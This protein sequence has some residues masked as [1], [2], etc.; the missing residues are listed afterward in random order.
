M[1]H[2]NN[3]SPTGNTYTT[4]KD[5]ADAFGVKPRTLNN[6]QALARSIEEVQTAVENN[7]IKSTTGFDIAR[8]DEQEQRQVMQKINSSPSKRLTGEDVKKII[9]EIKAIKPNTMLQ[10]DQSSN[11]QKQG[12]E[13]ISN[14]TAIT[15]TDDDNCVV[16]NDINNYIAYGQGDKYEQREFKHFIECV[17]NPECI[18]YYLK[19]LSIYQTDIFNTLEKYHTIIQNNRLNSMSIRTLNDDLQSQLEEMEEILEDLNTF[20]ESSDSVIDMIDN[21]LGNDEDDTEI[22]SVGDNGKLYNYKGQQIGYIV[23]YNNQYEYSYVGYLD[24]N[25][26][27]EDVAYDENDNLNGR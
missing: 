23:D 6:Y 8:L 9:E 1:R 7:L 14:N 11:F 22:W 25:N 18:S 4:M 13:T 15:T 24:E 26:T 10:L 2:G 12:K 20:I 27:G 16:L 3:F 17:N 21:I 5:L 19:Y